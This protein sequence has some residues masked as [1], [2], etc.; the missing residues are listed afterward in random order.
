MSGDK[1]HST[2]LPGGGIILPVKYFLLSLNYALMILIPIALGIFIHRR[3]GAGWRLFLMGGVTFVLSQLFHIPFNWAIQRA[4]MLP[5]DLSSWANLL[6]TALFLGLSAGV[7]E[8]T[9]RYLTYRYWAKDARSWSR[10]LMLGAGHGGTEAIIVGALA[11]VSFAGLVMTANNE[12][13]MSA[14]PAADQAIITDSLAGL[15]ATPWYGLLLGAAERVFAIAAHLAL[16][17]MVLQVFLRGSLRWLFLAIGYHALF[18][19][20]AVVGVTRTGPYAT[21]GLLAVFSLLS[22]YIIFKLR[23][24]EPP[25][26]ELQP[27]PL[28]VVEPADLQPTEEIIDRS[29]Y[30]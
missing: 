9:A 14:I 28:P 24:P 26:T 25:P 18:N 15:L 7:F 6:L 5:T 11:A 2:P 16:S 21:E 12:T 23:S 1:L 8:E 19:M 13:I 17:I 10:G 20:I 3:T 29:R 27:M 4:G 22:L 30:S